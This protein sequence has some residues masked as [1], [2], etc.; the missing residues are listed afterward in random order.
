MKK[1][2]L[3]T[4]ST[5]DL[6]QDYIEA[7]GIHVLPLKV[8]YRDREYVDRV[9]IQPEEVYRR[10]EEEVPTTSMPSLGEVTALFSRL[11]QEGY[12]EVL[13]IHISSGLSGTYNTVR[14]AA[15]QFSGLKLEVMDSLSISMGTGLLVQ[16][17][18]EL[19]QAGLGLAD[20]VAEISR[21]RAEMRVIFV[22]GTLE[23]LRRGG[24]IGH[25][26]ATMGSLLNLKPVIS[27]DGEGRYYTIA[28]VRGRKQSLQKMIDMATEAAAK[29][30]LKMVVMHADVREE[31]AAVVASIRQA[32]GM[33]EIPL[34]EVG[35]VVGVHAGPGLLGVVFYPL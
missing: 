4:D 28:K 21:I 15:E 25:V 26:A 3:V 6:S 8:V 24:R 31:A 14:M 33:A 32:T 9:E 20:I 10:L 34:G 22:V 27:V 7:N 11:K 35:P 13:A 1:I 5:G 19:I 23:Y 16:K 2:A 12:Q 29:G 18:A 17:A 30:P